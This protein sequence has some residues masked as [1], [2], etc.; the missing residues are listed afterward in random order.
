M[1]SDGPMPHRSWACLI[2]SNRLVTLGG[3][4]E[5]CSPLTVSGPKVWFRYSTTSNRSHQQ[6]QILKQGPFLAACF[7]QYSKTTSLPK[8]GHRR[9]K[10]SGSDGCLLI[11]T[12]ASFPVNQDNQRRWSNTTILMLETFMQKSLAWENRQKPLRIW[13]SPRR[14]I[15]SW[16]NYRKNIDR[17]SPNPAGRDRSS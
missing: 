13:Q 4:L 3:G 5:S 11:K 1:F 8:R 2:K 17:T 12:Y 10:L 7:K 6:S 9:D 15:R 14:S 16:S